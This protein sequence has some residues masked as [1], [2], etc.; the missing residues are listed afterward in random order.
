VLNVSEDSVGLF[1]IY[2][3]LKFIPEFSYPPCKQTLIYNLFGASFVPALPILPFPSC[4]WHGSILLTRAISVVGIFW[5][6]HFSPI[7]AFYAIAFYLYIYIFISLWIGLHSLHIRSLAFRT[8]SCLDF[9]V[10]FQWS[11]IWNWEFSSH[12]ISFN[13]MKF[14]LGK[15]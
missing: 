13:L 5:P 14:L 10:M 7:F 9:L 12:F 8:C 11:P 2:S 4:I 1:M 15:L 3:Y 6:C